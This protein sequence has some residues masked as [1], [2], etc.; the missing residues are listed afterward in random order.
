MNKMRIWLSEEE[1]GQSM[2]EYALAI[3]LIAVMSVY[4]LPKIGHAMAIHF[5]TI[6][7]SLYFNGYRP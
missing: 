3:V 7:G 1:S 6:S 4:T 2:V 5:N